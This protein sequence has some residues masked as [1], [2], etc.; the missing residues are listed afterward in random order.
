MDVLE[1]AKKLEKDGEGYYR[2]LAERNK[3]NPGVRR[4]MNMLADEEVK[5]YK[6]VSEMASGTPGPLESDVLGDARNI[7]VEMKERNEGVDREGAQTDMY[8]KAQDIEKKS[9]EFY[10]KCRDDS[11]DAPNKNVFD[12]LAKEERKHFFLLDNIVE[13]VSRPDTWLEDA[14]W[15]HLEEY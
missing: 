9:W 5:H 14:E 1:Y 11:E 12:R 4:I 3:G 6:V 8:R 7:F 13:F 10:E 2:E 15:H